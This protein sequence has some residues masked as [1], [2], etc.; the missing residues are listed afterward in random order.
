M[1]DP[2]NDLALLVRSGYGLIVIETTEEDRVEVLLRYL[3]GSLNLAYFIW[4][5]TKGLRRDG[6]ETAVYGTGTVASAL[7][8]IQASGV[9]AL[10]YLQDAE[11]SLQDPVITARFKDAVKGFENVTGA[12]VLAGEDVA[13]PPD[14][15]P[16]C[17]RVPLAPPS[18]DELRALLQNTL[19]DLAKRMPVQDRLS[20][21]DANRLLENLQGLTLLEARKVLTKAVIE[22][23]VLDADAIAKVAAA[24]M[25]VVA[26][27]GLLEYTPVS[28]KLEEVADLAGL[29]DWL[30]KRREI[31]ADPVRA[32]Q[33][34]L[35]F[36]KGVLLLGVQGC[37]KSLCA[38]AVA[39]AWGLPLLRMDPSNLYNKFVGESE[40]NFERATK[41]AE[42]VAPVVLWID[43]IEKAFGG[44]GT[45]ED[46]GV[47]DR[48]LGTFL[49]WMQDRAGDVF[50]VATANDI[51]KLPPELVRKGRFDEI[52]FVDLPK[53]EARKSILSIH[54]KKRC[55]DPATFD[56]D[57][58]VNATEG[59]SGAEIEQAVVSALYA[60]FSAKAPLTTQAV[61]KEITATHPLSQTMAEKIDNLR[62]WCA[63]RTVS[64]Q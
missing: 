4:T 37:G 59:F 46:G 44:S 2:L 60:A 11:A 63:E 64:A 47:S 39:G 33:F 24:K 21:E 31:L 53:A 29:K 55:W 26:R 51:T 50:V 18:L 38:K 6:V 19:D 23:G 57:A 15:E 9:P 56:L 7:D 16:L 54:L 41:T 36:P 28:E 48:I 52:F 27:E 14:L 35:P 40:K 45:G 62:R 10:Y 17:A 1:S 8:D 5:P 49:N 12:V 58:M 25:D 22:D 20:P 43:E 13:L 30:G 42:R 61:L 3:A 34:G 32:R